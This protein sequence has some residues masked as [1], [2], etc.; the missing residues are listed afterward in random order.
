MYY[1]HILQVGSYIIV[2]C[3]AGARQQHTQ[4]SI[5]YNVISIIYIYIY[6]IILC[7]Y[8]YDV[9]YTHFV[10]HCCSFIVSV[11]Y[12]C[13]QVFWKEK[14]NKHAYYYYYIILCMH[15][16]I[17]TKNEKD[18]T[19]CR[20]PAARVYK[21]YNLL[22]TAYIGYTCYYETYDEHT[23]VFNIIHT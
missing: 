12:Y 3:G 8:I 20:D 4:K 6:I 11:C 23:Q 7:I 14:K 13:S 5:A 10:K 15:N 9:H 1:V 22:L 17:I 21:Q 16:N 18:L 2:S 19:S